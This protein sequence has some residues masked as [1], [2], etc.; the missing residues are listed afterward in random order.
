MNSINI[1][2]KKNANIRWPTL[3]TMV[4]KVAFILAVL[5]PWRLPRIK[6]ASIWRS[7]AP[8]APD[9]LLVIRQHQSIKK[10]K[11]MTGSEVLEGSVRV[12]DP[13]QSK[14]C[15]IRSKFIVRLSVV[16]L[17]QVVPWLQK[18]P[19]KLIQ[20]N[21]GSVPPLRISWSRAR[22]SRDGVWEDSLITYTPRDPQ[23]N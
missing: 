20:R 18:W 1:N 9:K 8:R 6:A 14:L 5:A 10:L 23:K 12:V 11:R 16:P 22:C 13:L 7:L 4:F 3:A 19:R 17:P 15:W 2:F 21:W